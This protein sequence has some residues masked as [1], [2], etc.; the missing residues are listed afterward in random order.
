MKWILSSLFLCLFISGQA[1]N[2]QL[3][4]RGG[5][6]NYQGDLQEKRLSLRQAKPAISLGLRYDLSSRFTARLF[7]TY[8]KLAAADSNNTQPKLVERNLSFQTKLWDGELGLQFHFRDLNDYWW[9][10]YVFAGIGVFNYKPYTL[11]NLDN[12]VYLQPLGTEGQGF[13][14]GE[15]PYRL[16]QLS[17]PVGI[18]A[19]YALNEDMRIGIEMGY[20]IL[21]TDYLDDVSGRYVDQATLLANR[22]QEAVDLAYRGSDVYPVAG[23]KRGNEFNNDAYYFVQLT[24]T[25]RPFVDW[26]A[27]T[28][29]FAS[30]KKNKKVGCPATRQNR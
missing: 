22:G 19:E 15:E 17:L 28:S 23:D 18:G 25:I 7:L 11:N 3:G 13:I 30:F 1:Q 4:L 12:K 20:R 2:L 24:F 27:R 10:P 16:T 14:P 29:G 9:T 5:F 21:F 26:Y 8:S 6:S